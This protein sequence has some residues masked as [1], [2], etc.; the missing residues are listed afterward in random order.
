M[1]AGL[2]AQYPDNDQYNWQNKKR[3]PLQPFPNSVT[4]LALIFADRVFIVRHLRKKFPMHLYLY[5]KSEC[6]LSDMMKENRTEL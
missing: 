1:K 3:K 5:L 2:V 6:A 4:F